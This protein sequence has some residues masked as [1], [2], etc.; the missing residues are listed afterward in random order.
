MDIQTT[1]NTCARYSGIIYALKQEDYLLLN[2]F[3][4]KNYGHLSY[5]DLIQA[6]EWFAQGKL[7]DF[8]AYQNF[9][10]RFVGKVLGAYREKKAKIKRDNPTIIDTSHQLNEYK[11]TKEE[12]QERA[13]NFIKGCFERDEQILTA[14]WNDAFIYAERIEAINM[15]N[16]DKKKYFDNV[17]MDIKEEIKSKG[18]HVKSNRLKLKKGIPAP[19]V[20][21]ECRKRLLI[22]YFKNNV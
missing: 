7:G 18:L 9:S 16:E 14:N 5:G 3:I 17:E 1:I 22:K 20:K 11:T 4:K 8:E 6:F 21:T 15:T 19:T 2:D 10:P 13:F 12:D